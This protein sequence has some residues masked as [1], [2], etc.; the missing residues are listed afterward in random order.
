VWS[1]GRIGNSETNGTARLCSLR[2]GVDLLA[3]GVQA[4]LVRMDGYCTAL[5]NERDPLASA[6]T[7]DTRLKGHCGHGERS[8]GGV[9]SQRPGWQR[10]VRG[11]RNGRRRRMSS[12]P[13][14]RAQSLCSDMDGRPG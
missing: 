11:R 3:A 9:R 10:A 6:P 5:V 12:S 1:G 7:K 4:S 8:C 14:A 13:A 2:G